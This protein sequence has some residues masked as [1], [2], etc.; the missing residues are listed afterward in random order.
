MQRSLYVMFLY[1][2]TGY[3]EESPRAKDKA[4]LIASPK[5]LAVPW[6]SV[7]HATLLTLG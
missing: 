7:L 3:L 2:T 4:G 1:E 5:A 6:E